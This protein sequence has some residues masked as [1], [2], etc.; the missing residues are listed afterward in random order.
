M[1]T[2]TKGQLRLR[3][4]LATHPLGWELRLS[5]RDELSRSQVC[6]TE[7]EVFDTS[8]AWRAEAVTKGWAE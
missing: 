2:M 8:D 6:K 3:C 1:W 5:V 7:R 4:A